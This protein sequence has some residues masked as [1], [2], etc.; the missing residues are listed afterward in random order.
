[1]RGA[2]VVPLISALSDI[3]PTARRPLALRMGLSKERS[4]LPAACT[5][6]A[7]FCCRGAIPFAEKWSFGPASAR[8]SICAVPP[9]RSAVASRLAA[10]IA[11]AG[12]VRKRTP[13][14]CTRTLPLGE[15]VVPVTRA[16]A[17]SRPEAWSVGMKVLARSGVTLW[18]E[19]VRSSVGVI[20]PATVQ[21]RG[22]EGDPQPVDGDRRCRNR[23][24]RA[25]RDADFRFC[26]PQR[27][28]AG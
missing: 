17:V 14:A 4:N 5:A 27:A 24:A 26:S 13:L 1:M 7:A 2:A 9:C 23:Y 18:R 22:A 20:L 6:N 19:A 12:P 15:A 21:C 11:A 25:P 16:S 3:R 10:G 28:L 8:R